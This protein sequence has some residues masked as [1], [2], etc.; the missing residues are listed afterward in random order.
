M[1]QTN[2][3]IHE[4]IVP[5]RAV[6]SKISCVFNTAFNST[7]KTVLAINEVHK[8][9]PNTLSTAT[10]VQPT[11]K[12]DGTC[13]LIR[14]NKLWKRYDRKLNK[15]G[16]RKNKAFQRQLSMLGPDANPKDILQFDVNTDF[17]V[18]PTGWIPADGEID[19][20]KLNI[21]HNQHCVGWVPI[22]TTEKSDKWHWSVF[23]D[24]KVLLLVPQDATQLV[25]KAVPTEELN[26]CSFELVGSKVNNNP[27]KFPQSEKQHFL[28]PHGAVSL[29]DVPDLNDQ[30]TTDDLIKWFNQSQQAGLE[31]IVWHITTN[32][33]IIMLKIHR[34]HLGLEWPVDNPLF[35]YDPDWISQINE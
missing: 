1:S 15:E 35:M 32:D 27:Y 18:P 30:L 12:F 11:A 20:I 22:S 25:V 31:G 28:V 21:V 17:K 26:E 23:R 8:T 14:D 3:T 19:N 34:H 2:T 13:C 29:F 5:R 10:N 6:Q 7:H 24:Q 33:K 4:V 16:E 9:L